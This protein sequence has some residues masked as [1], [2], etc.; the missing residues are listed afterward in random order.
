MTGS[1]VPS[2]MENENGNAAMHAILGILSSLSDHEARRRVH[3]YV[4]EVSMS[5]RVEDERKGWP[6]TNVGAVMTPQNTQEK[7]N[8]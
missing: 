4:A 8:G 1:A 7:C 5:Q 6:T 2:R 3:Q